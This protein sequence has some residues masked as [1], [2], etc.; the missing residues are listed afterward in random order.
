MRDDYSRAPAPQTR[1]D[2]DLD[3]DWPAD[4]IGPAAHPLR[5]ADVVG[6]F[7]IPRLPGLP[8]IGILQDALAQAVEHRHGVVVLGPMGTGKS[9]GAH[10]A[11]EQWLEDERRLV[12]GS[13]LH[14]RRRVVYHHGLT[15][16]SKRELF[17]DLLQRAMPG[18]KVSLYQRG[19]RKADDALREELYQVYRAQNVV[20]LI[21]DDAQTL[22]DSALH[23]LRDLMATRET[24][25]YRTVIVDDRAATPAVGVGVVL[26]GTPDLES[27]VL[28]TGETHGH[29]RW[30]FRH[31]VPL[32]SAAHLG[33]IY[34]AVFPCIAE[35]PA[36]TAPLSFDA[37]LAQ[38][39][40]RGR[41]LPVRLVCTHIREYVGRL[42]AAA[43][44]RVATAR[45]VAFDRA[46][47][48]D[49]FRKAEWEEGPARRRA[50]D[51][52]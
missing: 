6:R 13:T 38:H 26:V 8:S 37:F 40:A 39:L 52:R 47:F 42:G 45:D 17:A 27:R 24:D 21:V 49:T 33:P 5:N 20:A 46:L 11:C 29:G 32:L 50:T 44:E 36:A 35:D 12:M 34:R 25:P 2:D 10:A 23:G 28:A 15:A 4:G 43:P 14:Q 16:R 18:V 19:Q 41:L 30:Q 48:L 3:A 51:R 31:E 22:S 1:L 7:V 9:E